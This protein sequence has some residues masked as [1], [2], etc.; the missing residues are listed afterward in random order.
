M[1]NRR[2]FL[3]GGAATATA[4]LTAHLPALAPP[5]VYAT[6]PVGV[7]TPLPAAPDAMIG[8]DL[9]AWQLEVL[10]MVRRSDYSPERTTL[11]TATEQN[12]HQRARRKALMDAIEQAMDPARRCVPLDIM[13]LPP[14]Q[15]TPAF[16]L[17]TA[18]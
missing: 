6:G 13:F 7:L 4:A 15:R 2:A 10:D 16:N 18:I 5:M 8:C 17:D 3:A 14:V 1:M 9:Q 12:V 11:A